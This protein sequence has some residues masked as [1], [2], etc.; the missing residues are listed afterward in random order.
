[1]L[2]AISCNGSSSAVG[3]DSLQKQRANSKSALHEAYNAYIRYEEIIQALITNNQSPWHGI[4]W[5]HLIIRHA[6]VTD[7]LGTVYLWH[8]LLLM[9]AY[10]SHVMFEFSFEA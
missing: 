1:M 4:C 7:A 2:P 5:H 3:V 6:S 10:T 8:P 9:K